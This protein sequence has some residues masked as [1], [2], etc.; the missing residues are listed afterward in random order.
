MIRK[1]A[2]ATL[3]LVAMPSAH[4]QRPWYKWDS[5]KFAEPGLRAKCVEARLRY[6]LPRASQFGVSVDPN[7][8]IEN[9]GKSASGWYTIKVYSEYGSPS[10]EVM[11]VSMRLHSSGEGSDGRWYYTETLGGAAGPN[12]RRVGASVEFD[13][14]YGNYGGPLR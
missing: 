6:W 10:K 2:I 3:F 5:I 8:R 4:A 11:T 12:W 9:W 7:A 13:C 14:T 1:L